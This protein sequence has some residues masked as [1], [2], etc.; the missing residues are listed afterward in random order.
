MKMQLVEQLH[1]VWPSTEPFTL[2]TT[3]PDN[4]IV[5][6]N[7]VAWMLLKFMGFMAASVP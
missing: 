3:Y 4:R 6:R 5:V 1:E 2:R 7:P